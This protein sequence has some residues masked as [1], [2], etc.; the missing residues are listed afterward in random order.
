[1]IC[2]LLNTGFI[3]EESMKIIDSYKELKKAYSNVTID[4]I[5]D[6]INKFRIKQNKAK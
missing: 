6:A 5:I 3:L 2:K 1:M 4:T